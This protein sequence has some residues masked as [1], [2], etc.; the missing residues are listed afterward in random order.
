MVIVPVVVT[1]F[2]PVIAI[3]LPAWNSMLVTVPP[4]SGNCCDCQVLPVL[5]NTLPATPGATEL[6]GLVP[7]PT[8][9][10]FVGMLLTPVPPNT[11]DNGVVNPFKDVI[12]E[13]LPEAAANKLVLAAAAVLAPVPPDI[14]AIG[15][16]PVIDPPVMEIAFEFCKAIV[17]MLAV[18]PDPSSK[19]VLASAA[20][21]APVPPNTIGTATVADNVPPLLSTGP[22]MMLLSD[23]NPM[24]VILPLV[25]DTELEFC[26][27]MLPRPKLIRAP[28]FVFEPVPPEANGIGA[29]N[30]DTVPPVIATAPAFCKLIE[31]KLA[32]AACTKAV[33][34]I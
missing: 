32:V 22:V 16:I 10:A 26:S 30:P 14:T 3:A 21:L 13:L 11:T 20:L 4:A 25:I 27:A 29:L 17:P 24:L 8:T 7:F 31:P 15:D 12:S 34:A 5:I 23:S 6:T 1:G 33:E 9:R 2:V 18:A 28:A 19:F